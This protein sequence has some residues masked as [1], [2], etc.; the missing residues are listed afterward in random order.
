MN[1]NGNHALKIRVGQV[2][3]FSE[4]QVASYSTGEPDRLPWP[5][6]PYSLP[7]SWLPL[8]LSSLLYSK[9][10]DSPKSAGL[11]VVVVVLQPVCA[12]IRDGI[13][14]LLSKSSPAETFFVDSRSVSA[15]SSSESDKTMLTYSVNVYSTFSPSSLDDSSA[16]K[17]ETTWSVVKRVRSAAILPERM[18]KFHRLYGVIRFTR[19][20]LR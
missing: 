14:P 9:M 8:L 3:E 16:K 12:S 4:M 1:K 11:R 10:N 7:L 20:H 15:L 13:R 19:L 5:S 17:K 6:L 18:R 2:A